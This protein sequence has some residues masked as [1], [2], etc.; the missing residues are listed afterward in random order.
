MKVD[1]VKGVVW[2]L[3][4]VIIDVKNVDILGK[5]KIDTGNNKKFNKRYLINLSNKR[6]F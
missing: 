2:I 4:L 1:L 6:N 5:Q 3:A